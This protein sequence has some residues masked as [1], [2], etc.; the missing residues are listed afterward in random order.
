MPKLERSGPALVAL[1]NVLQSDDPAT[2]WVCKDGRVL[3]I[4]EMEYAHRCNLLE[5]LLK[6]S[7]GINQMLNQPALSVNEAET[8]LLALPWV[9]HLWI[10]IQAGSSPA[11]S[12]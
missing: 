2:P 12:E 1:L 6:R 4:R 5:W 10:S 7:M 9:K 3:T 11:A 8:K